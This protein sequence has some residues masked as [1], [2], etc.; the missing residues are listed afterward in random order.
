VSVARLADPEPAV[1]ALVGSA[2]CEGALAGPLGS[3]PPAAEPDLLGSEADVRD[4]PRRESV[5]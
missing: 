1:T 2:A 4:E 5:R 3:A